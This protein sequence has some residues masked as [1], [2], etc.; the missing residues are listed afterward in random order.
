MTLFALALSGLARARFARIA[1]MAALAVGLVY[2][3]V[4]AAAT[5]YIVLDNPH[6]LR[7]PFT[8]QITAGLVTAAVL[9][10]GL[11][12]VV[13]SGRLAHPERTARPA[14]ASSPR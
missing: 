14:R 12:F 7:D 10:S 1:M 9:L 3:A 13:A 5:G 8:W 4:G 6:D 11:L 2:A